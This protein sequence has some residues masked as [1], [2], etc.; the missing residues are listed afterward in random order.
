MAVSNHM[1]TIYLHSG[2]FFRAKNNI[3]I[4]CGLMNGSTSLLALDKNIS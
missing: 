2:E 3:V 1:R 4:Q